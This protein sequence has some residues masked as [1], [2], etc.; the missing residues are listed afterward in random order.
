MKHSY[1]KLLKKLLEDY[2]R[3]QACDF[4]DENLLE[5]YSANQK[6][7][8][9]FHYLAAKK[10]IIL[11]TDVCSK[12]YDVDIT[13]KGL[14]YFEDARQDKIRFWIPV[15][16]SI[17]ALILSIISLINDIPKMPPQ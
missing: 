9:A 1:K 17:F 10:L 6:V 4:V 2:Y 5:Q 3:D 15:I 13:E 14:T 7:F 16:I 11:R 8:K 12:L